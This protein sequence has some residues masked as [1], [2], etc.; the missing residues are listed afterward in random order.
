MTVS[1]FSHIAGHVAIQ[2][3]HHC[4]TSTLL[5]I[6]GHAAISILFTSK[7]SH[8]VIPRCSRILWGKLHYRHLHIG[9][10]VN[11]IC[12]WVSTIVI[13]PCSHIL[14]GMSQSQF[15]PL[16]STAHI[17]IPHCPRSSQGTPQYKLR[18]SNLNPLLKHSHIMTS[19]RPCISR[20]GPQYRCYNHT[21]ILFFFWVLAIVTPRRS[22]TLWGML[23]SHFNSLFSLR[24][25]NCDTSQPS[26]IVVCCNT[27]PLSHISGCAAI[28]IQVSA[29]RGTL[30]LL[31]FTSV[32]P[33]IVASCCSR[34]LLQFT[35]HI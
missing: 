8:I 32:H 22:Y 27:M 28:L 4:D 20:G 21:S 33:C 11:F 30:N 6:A 1:P 12:F 14:Q 3:I 16:P 9:V 7:H 35:F 17:V 5:H 23:Q 19:Q 26:H 10:A 29:D 13:P 15:L 2:V 25:Y 31:Q 24:F 34:V 18:C